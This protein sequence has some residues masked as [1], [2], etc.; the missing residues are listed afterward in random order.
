M[1]YFLSLFSSLIDAT[2][3]FISFFAILLMARYATL[4][5]P[6]RTA[7]IELIIDAA[8]FELRHTCHYACFSLLLFAADAMLQRYS[9]R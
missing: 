6:M 1:L 7:F 8:M 5:L 2:L 4:M 9:R 3:S